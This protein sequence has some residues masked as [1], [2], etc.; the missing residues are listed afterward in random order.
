MPEIGKHFVCIFIYVA[1][2]KELTAENAKE[3]CYDYQKTEL[4][5]NDNIDKIVFLCY[6]NIELFFSSNMI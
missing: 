4:L 5:T 6:D 3:L 2:K 1:V